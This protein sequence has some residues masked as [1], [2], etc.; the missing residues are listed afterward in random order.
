[1]RESG[2]RKQS[3]QSSEK[4]VFFQTGGSHQAQPFA[5]LRYKVKGEGAAPLGN[6]KKG[7]SSLNSRLA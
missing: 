6:L 1:M 3:S 2:P 4:P 7:L 5:E